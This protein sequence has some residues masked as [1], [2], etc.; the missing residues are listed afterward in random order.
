MTS[1]GTANG[2]SLSGAP[3]VRALAFEFLNISDDEPASVVYIT[4]DSTKNICQFEVA[5]EEPV[6]LTSSSWIR[7]TFSSLIGS[8]AVEGGLEVTTSDPARWAIEFVTSG[9][10]RYWRLIPQQSI[11]LSAGQRLVFRIERLTLNA[12]TQEGQYPLK[13]EWE[14][15]GTDASQQ[16]LLVLRSRPGAGDGRM[17]ALIWGCQHVNQDWNVEQNGERLDVTSKHVDEIFVNTTPNLVLKSPIAFFLT[18]VDSEQPVPKRDRSRFQVGF[19]TGAGAQALILNRAEEEEQSFDAVELEFVGSSASTQ[20]TIERRTDAGVVYWEVAP[21]GEHF[22][23]P[24][25]IVSFVLRG[26]LA[27]HEPGISAIEISYF[28]FPGYR[29][30][31]VHIPIHKIRPYAAIVDAFWTE[32]SGEPELSWK[33]FGSQ[34]IEAQVYGEYGKLHSIK[35]PAHG[36][37]KLQRPDRSLVSLRVKEQ[38][39]MGHVEYMPPIHSSARSSA[40]EAISEEDRAQ[41][42][43]MGAFVTF[44]LRNVSAR[45]R[46]SPVLFVTDDATDNLC[47]LIVKS[48]IPLRFLLAAEITMAFAADPG[49]AFTVKPQTSRWRWKEGTLTA[50]DAAGIR[51]GP[52]QPVIFDVA[53]VVVPKDIGPGVQWLVVEWNISFS[54]PVF[55]QCI[56]VFVSMFRPDVAP[57]MPIAVEFQQIAGV[58]VQLGGAEYAIPWKGKG[59][60]FANHN[61]DELG[62]YGSSLGFRIAN[63]TFATIA[64]SDASRVE[65]AF[66]QGTAAGALLLLHDNDLPAAWVSLHCVGSSSGTTWSVTRLGGTEANYYRYELTPDGPNFLEKDEVVF[67]EMKYLCPPSLFGN[68]PAIHLASAVLGLAA[69]HVA[70]CDVP[71]YQD[72]VTTLWVRKTVARPAV[73][74]AFYADDMIT[75]LRPV[76]VHWKVFGSGV[77]IRRFFLGGNV[78]TEP[79]LSDLPRITAEHDV[80]LDVLITQVVTVA[81]DDMH[82]DKRCVVMFAARFS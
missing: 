20:W 34:E 79:I 65:V 15:S 76:K 36:T 68:N 19:R 64:R 25:E 81:F 71:E 26:V 57:A 61:R 41:L 43:F 47:R 69:I 28:D 17:E 23:E 50:L 55:K 2:E 42:P 18:N 5:T 11:E 53:D 9:R 31:T 6:T 24:S 33:S 62:W 29:N 77:K 37:Q 8:E 59:E 51:V 1:V 32:G 73:M 56:P 21:R 72:R 52:D 82:G 46:Q 35:L 80:D 58:N 66:S 54:G 44:E 38:T 22:F 75:K 48:N 30:G 78:L 16:D 60:V 12:D 14:L 45:G 67:F 40:V 70:Q 27:N 13:I 74:E 3:M 7:L 49:I 4:D 10:L 63:D 39:G